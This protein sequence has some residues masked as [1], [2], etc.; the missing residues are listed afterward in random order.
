M[1]AKSHV[2]KQC[3]SRPVHRGKHLIVDYSQTAKA[4][5]RA[6]CASRFRR[7]TGRHANRFGLATAHRPNHVRPAGIHEYL[8]GQLSL[9]RSAGAIGFG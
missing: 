7:G 3:V 1:E 9:G 8:V 5:G 4:G 2:S 6:S